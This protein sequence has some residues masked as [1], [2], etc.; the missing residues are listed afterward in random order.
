MISPEIVAKLARH[1]N[2][3]GIK[4]SSRDFDYFLQVLYLTQSV[5]GFKVLTGTETLIL[6]ALAVGGQG[7]VVASG[8]IV[9]GWIADLARH[10][11]SGNLEQARVNEHQLIELANALRQADGIRGFKFAQSLIDHYDGHLLPPY[12]PLDKESP[13]AMG[14]RTVLNRYHLIP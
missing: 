1:P 5:P 2:I 12:H 9:P 4:D 10:F 11:E 6:P 14:I 3:M 13:Q 8:N 7:A